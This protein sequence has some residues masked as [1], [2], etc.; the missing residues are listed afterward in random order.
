MPLLDHF[1]SPMLEMMPWTGIHSRWATAIADDLNDRLLPPGFRAV[2]NVWLGGGD[3][4]IDVATLRSKGWLGPNGAGF[5][6][7][8]APPS[9]TGTAV[10]DF[11]ALDVFEVK[12][13]YR[14]D[15]YKLMGAVEMVSHANKDRPAN[16][17]A[18]AMKCANYIEQNAAVLYVDVVTNAGGNLHGEILEILEL[19]AQAWTST[20]GLSAVA[21]RSRREN[22]GTH[23]EWFPNELAIG[24]VLPT[25]P[26]WIGADI[27]IPI[28][29]ESTYQETFRRLRI[30]PNNVGRNGP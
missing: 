26:L 6:S 5:P 23:I 10:V 28:D 1:R 4:E 17:R 30:N 25:V 27:C 22:G 15:E 21:Y 11:T 2:A 19:D 29:L 8:W 13:L 24:K 18:L 3:V 16:R 7:S 12:I 20:T 9:P 14:S